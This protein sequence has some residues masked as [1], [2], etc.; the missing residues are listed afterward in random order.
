[1]RENLDSVETLSQLL[2][3]TYVLQAKTQNYHWHLQSSN[4]IALH[5]LFETQYNE[6]RDGIDELAERIRILGCRAPA[7][8]AQFLELSSIPEDEDDLTSDEEMLQ[9]LVDA[10]THI[11]T[12][13]RTALEPLKQ[14]NDDGTIDLLVERL[15]AHEKMHWVLDSHMV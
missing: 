2:A 9:A 3:D 7:T 15:R 11:I 4:F 13:L 1:M 14:G 6:M 10:H 12:N 5:S 8:L